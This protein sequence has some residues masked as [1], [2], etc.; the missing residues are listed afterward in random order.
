MGRW[1]VVKS[2]A[3]ILPQDSAKSE[4]FA[5]EGGVVLARGSG[6]VVLILALVAGDAAAQSTLPD[7]P[8]FLSAAAPAFCSVEPTSPPGPPESFSPGFSPLSFDPDLGLHLP[9]RRP[10]F[11]PGDIARLANPQPFYGRDPDGDLKLRVYSE[12]LAALQPG[13]INADYD[14]PV[15]DGLRLTNASA[16]GQTDSEDDTA[17]KSF[18]SR[19]GLAYED[20]GIRFRMNPAAAI[21][22]GELAGSA[23]RRVG[24]DNQIST[25][26]AQDLTLTLSS[27]YDAQFHPGN[28]TADSSTERHRIALARHFASGWRLG[29]SV[30][31]R[32][33]YGYQQ[34]K[35]LNI[36][37]LMVGVPL[38]QDL[39]LTA[40][41]EFGLSE[42]RDFST[43]S[44][45]PIAGNRQSLD[46]Q[47]HWTPAALASRAMTLMAGYSLSQE[48]TDGVADPYLTQARINL[49]MKF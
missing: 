33:E 4:P 20:Y 9:E 2:G 23:S 46:L 13:G 22:W 30:Q 28:P 42:K 31:R 29:S 14:L 34:E 47:L 44:A 39:A 19:F 27:G 36:L 35:D 25:T 49:A 37:G 21:N 26:L 3:A 48:A 24:I 12:D 16:L 18:D 10:I 7:C 11:G 8:L 41:Q 1:P 15:F 32:I 38:G 5:Y 6:I 40:S 43:G 17:A 45:L